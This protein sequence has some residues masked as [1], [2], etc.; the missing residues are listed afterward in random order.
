MLTI[1]KGGP[2]IFWPS[3]ICNTLPENPANKIL[4]GDSDFDIFIDLTVMEVEGVIGTL[5]TLLP[6]YT[7]VDIYEGRLLFTLMNREKETKY[8]ELPYPIY[9][10]VDLNFH[11][12]HRK[13]EYVDI[14]INGGLSLHLDIKK[15][16]F[17][18]EN[19]P[20]IIFGAGNFPKNGFNLNYTELVLH[21][22]RVEQDG[23]VLC[24]HDFEEF[25]FDKS[26][27]ITGN[28]NFMNKL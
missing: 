5:F 13:N 8:W 28:C 26:V 25:I 2:W 24:K 3:H 10:E 6:H 11:I 21:H 16:G 14:F 22:F 17:A 20:H 12:R 4:T 19:D 9:D 27:D 7:A 1:N 15:E 18:V 23:E